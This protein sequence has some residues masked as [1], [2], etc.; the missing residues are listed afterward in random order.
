MTCSSITRRQSSL[1]NLKICCSSYIR[2]CILKKKVH[3]TCFFRKKNP[4]NN[5][6]T[7]TN[8]LNWRPY[9]PQPRAMPES[10]NGLVESSTPVGPARLIETDQ[11]GPGQAPPSPSTRPALRRPPQRDPRLPARGRYTPLAP[12]RRRAPRGVRPY[13]FLR[14][15]PPSSLCCLLLLTNGGGGRAVLARRGAR[16]RLDLRRGGRS[17][18]VG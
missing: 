5:S 14:S 8:I 2:A 7:N 13:F 11:L 1:T 10:P 9:Q 6:P 12:R 17:L 3:D 18:V 4:T 16:R 15:L